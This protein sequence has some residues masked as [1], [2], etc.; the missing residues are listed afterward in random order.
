M[1]C[2]VFIL[3]QYQSVADVVRVLHTSELG[4]PC[5]AHLWSRV[6]VVREKEVEV[7]PL[8]TRFVVWLAMT[9]TVAAIPSLPLSLVL[10]ACSMPDR[11]WRQGRLT[12][13]SFA[14]WAAS[15]PDCMEPGK[16]WEWGYKL[17]Y[18]KQ[19]STYVEKFLAGE[20]SAQPQNR[21]QLN[22]GRQLLPTIEKRLMMRSACRLSVRNARQ[23]RFL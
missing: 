7:Q 6:G 3:V 9:N 14:H 17:N 13:L 16:T 18:L 21:G 15:F 8:W 11:N 12:I 2:F 23:Q 1:F 19:F 20:D 5:W 10:I 4:D 22:E